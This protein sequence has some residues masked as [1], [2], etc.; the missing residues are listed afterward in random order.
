MNARRSILA[1]SAAAGGVF[2]AMSFG[3]GTATADNGVWI[4]NPDSDSPA[5]IVS[6]SGMPPYYQTTVE[7]GDFFLEHLHADGSLYAGPANGVLY[8]S[9]DF[10]MTNQDLVIG[11]GS[12]FEPNS[13]IDVTNFGGGYENIYADIAAYQIPGTVTP[14]D[15][16]TDTLVTPFGDFNV[17]VSFVADPFDP[18]LSAS[19]GAATDFVTSLDADWAALVALF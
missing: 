9:N 5:E 17:P 10:G 19:P 16:I 18:I 13:V 14:P 8:F 4:I 2:A 12:E 11:G 15:S 6:E 1:L 3:A 7:Q